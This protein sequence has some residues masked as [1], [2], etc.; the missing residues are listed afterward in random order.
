MKTNNNTLKK[1]PGN[2]EEIP[3]ILFPFNSPTN[4]LSQKKASLTTNSFIEEHPTFQEINNNMSDTFIELL[5]DLLS[6]P[7]NIGWFQYC[8]NICTINN[9]LNYIAIL[10][11]LLT[12]YIIFITF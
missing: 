3:Q 9:R 6:K 2:P 1:L 8:V 7:N 10:L 12:I 5:D 4:I 11:F